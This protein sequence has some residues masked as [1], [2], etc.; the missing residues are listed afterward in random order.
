[1]KLLILLKHSFGNIIIYHSNNRLS[2]H[3]LVN[4]F[5]TAARISSSLI[6]QQQNTSSLFSHYQTILV[7]I[8]SSLFHHPSSETLTQLWKEH[9]IPLIL[10]GFPLIILFLFLVAFL[11]I[12]AFRQLRKSGWLIRQQQQQQHA[13]TLAWFGGRG[14]PSTGATSGGSSSP[15]PS[16]P[17]GIV[18]VN[19]PP[20]SPPNLDKI[21]TLRTGTDPS[22]KHEFDQT[23]QDDDEDDQYNIYHNNLVVHSTYSSSGSNSSNLSMG[24]QSMLREIE[25]RIDEP[26]S[27]QELLS[28]VVMKKNSLS[29]FPSQ[30]TTTRMRTFKTYS[31]SDEEEEMNHHHADISPSWFNHTKPKSKGRNNTPPLRRTT[32]TNEGDEDKQYSKTVLDSDA[33]RNGTKNISQQLSQDASKTSL[34]NNNNNNTTTASLTTHHHHS[35]HH[36]HHHHSSF[37][38]SST[39]NVPQLY[40]KSSGNDPNDPMNL[41]DTVAPELGVGLERWKAIRHAW[42]TGEFCKDKKTISALNDSREDHRD[43]VDVD[44]IVEHLVNPKKPSF[45][46]PIPLKEMI[47]ILLEI[48]ESDGLFE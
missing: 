41:Y 40:T 43:S 21:S 46:K 18:V 22:L 35:H 15:S 25:E 7:H 32:T 20:T 11:I 28:R 9:P 5:K 8:T 37:I 23:N 13:T 12:N 29:T 14:H 6:H 31:S 1:M 3:H 17:D 45:Q 36:H 33:E 34:S 10:I 44:A 2:L 39:N 26:L 30:T 19:H 42:V 4:S 24:N 47:Q 38:M 16:S 27:E 48:W